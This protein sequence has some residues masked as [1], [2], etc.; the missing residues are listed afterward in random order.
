MHIKLKLQL[1]YIRQVSRLS[2]LWSQLLGV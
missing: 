2:E 1:S